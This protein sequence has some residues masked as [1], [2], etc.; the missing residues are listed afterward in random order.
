MFRSLAIAMA[1]QAAAAGRER[2]D[3]K[4]DAAEAQQ[5]LDDTLAA[6]AEVLGNDPPP[7]FVE[8]D[9]HAPDFHIPAGEGSYRLAPYIQRSTTDPRRV[10]GTLGSTR[11]PVYTAEL[12][13]AP[14]VGASDKCFT[15]A[16][17]FFRLLHGGDAVVEV[18]LREA[19]KTGD[20]GLSAEIARYSHLQDSL[21]GIRAKLQALEYQ[22]QG[23]HFEVNAS[24]WRLQRAQASRRLGWLENA[25]LGDEAINQRDNGRSAFLR[26][27]LPR[28]DDILPTPL[29][30]RAAADPD[31]AA[32]CGPLTANLLSYGRGRPTA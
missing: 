18:V 8:N 29:R 28:D 11:D 21:R 19:D 6:E 27:P 22:L 1:E 9:G 2:D 14:Y 23:L 5:R 15:I 24:Q 3:A 13:A 12:F 20:W 4:F 31:A 30:T 26:Y 7:G 17:W 25:H 10:L 32:S 16:P